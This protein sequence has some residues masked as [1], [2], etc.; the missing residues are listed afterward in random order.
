[1]VVREATAQ[2]GLT[3]KPGIEHCD[4]SPVAWRVLDGCDDG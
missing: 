2:L 3:S 4:Q 1:M